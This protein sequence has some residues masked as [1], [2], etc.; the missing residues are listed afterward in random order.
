LA[1]DPRPIHVHLGPSHILCGPTLHSMVPSTSWC[2]ALFIVAVEFIPVQ[3]SSFLSRALDSDEM[4]ALSPELQS[5]ILQEIEEMLGNDNRQ[6]TT[7]IRLGRVEE[8]MQTTF[9]AMPKN[10]QGK[11]NHA[12]VRYTLHSY[13]VQHHAWYVRGLAD[14]GEESNAT[15]PQGILQDRVEEFVQGVFEARLGA[16]GLNL[17]E[18]SV[19]AATFENLVYRES[20]VRLN[21]TL[22]LLQMSRTKPQ[23]IVQV[24]KV[25]DTYMMGYIMALNFSRLV[26]K[27][28]L[29]VQ[30][31]VFK[32]YPTWGETR[33]WLREIREENSFHKSFF[34]RAD[35]ERFVEHIGDQYG[36]WQDRECR[37]LKKQLSEVEDRSIGTNGSGRVRISDFYGSALN[38]GNWQFSESQDYLSKL[39]AL[40]THDPKVARVIIP[41]YINSP[42]NC[43]A[44]SKFYSVCCINECEDLMDRIEHHFAAPF[45]APQKVADFV[46]AL[47]SSTVEAGREL[48]SVLKARLQEI[49]KHHSGRVPLHS[50]LFAQWMH[51][52]YPRECPYPHMAGATRPQTPGDWVSGGQ[53]KATVSREEML[54]VVEANAGVSPDDEHQSHE[55]TAWSHH[56]ELYVGAA[57]AAGGLG[58][59][60][61]PIAYLTLA[62]AAAFALVQRL[63]SSG[64]KAAVATGYRGGHKDLFV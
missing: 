6:A 24:D 22:D 60:V 56:E 37:T 27:Q 9:K 33:Q 46:A 21:A 18:I 30:K 28:L 15:A 50:R 39:G 14:L 32:V 8:A 35:L 13:F 47:P 55:C 29:I 53:Q 20:M 34:T 45:V 36:R 11:L 52:A 17:R 49:A 10:E 42:S 25:L 41:N 16:H 62:A 61:R 12:A 48:H 3:G 1:P 26:P 64:K 63:L 23:D 59:S 44:S 4:E 54:K 7:E 19:L 58:E 40:D 57:F 43:L 38:G 51:H 5:S 31:N 2:A